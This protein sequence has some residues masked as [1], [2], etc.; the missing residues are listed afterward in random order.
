MKEEVKSVSKEKKN[1]KELLIELTKEEV[2]A[3]NGKVTEAE[4]K[5][6]R[7]QADLVNYRKRKDDEVAK[8]LTYANEDL[9]EELL[10]TLDNFERAIKMDDDNLEDEV[11]KFLSGMKMV[12]AS[13]TQALE[14]FGVREIEA[15]DKKFDPTYHQAV[16]TDTDDTKDKEMILEVYQKGYMLKDKVLRPAMVK[17]NK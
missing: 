14:K 15:L 7:A 5:F 4:E 2:E 6:L 11:S 10:P 12:Y 8:M 17:V 16:M 1:K 13:L 9:I 3:M